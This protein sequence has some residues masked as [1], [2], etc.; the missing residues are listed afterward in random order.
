ME[1]AETAPRPTT[2]CATTA[3]AGGA[4]GSNE[5]TQPSEKPAASSGDAASAASDVTWPADTAGALSRQ[6]SA[7]CRTSHRQRSPEPPPAAVRVARAGCHASERGESRSDTSAGAADAC[8]ALRRCGPSADAYERQMR[9][10]PSDE[11]AASVSALTKAESLSKTSALTR[12]PAGLPFAN[13][14]SRAR[15]AMSQTLMSSRAEAAT[16]S[17]KEACS[18]SAEQRAEAFSSVQCCSMTGGAAPAPAPLPASAA[19][20][21]M[22]ATKLPT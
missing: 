4:R 15:R 14:S 3:A 18:A 2:S 21:S 19:S 9:T 8:H 16:T 11:P 10:Q 17:G 5:R 13:V 1:T 7:S 6:T 20:G 12:E 22:S